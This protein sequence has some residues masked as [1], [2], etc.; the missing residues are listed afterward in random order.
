MQDW[1]HLGEELVRA[2]IRLGYVKRTE[3]KR[4]LGFSHDRTL[5]DLELGKRTNYEQATLIQAEEWYG[6][7]KGNI[8]EILAGGPVRYADGTGG[9]VSTVEHALTGVLLDLP[10]SALEGLSPVERDEVR[11]SAIEAA[12][13]RAR[14]IRRE[15]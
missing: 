15:Q 8:R 14:E 4:A 11:A 12:L 1:Q 9:N 3:M 13:R 10:E 6:L 7:A 2:R 5:S